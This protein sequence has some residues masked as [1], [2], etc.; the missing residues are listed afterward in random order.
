M[1]DR[2][3]N[4]IR[5]KQ[6]VPDTQNSS[7]NQYTMLA[8]NKSKPTEHEIITARMF[9]YPISLNRT[10][11]KY[12]N[13]LIGVTHF[14]YSNNKKIRSPSCLNTKCSDRPVKRDDL[15]SL[16]KTANLNSGD[17][18]PSLDEFGQRKNN[19]N[20]ECWICGK[21]GNNGEVFQY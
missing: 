4:I 6:R 10:T 13:E 21:L 11:Y 19:S 1:E 8:P 16:L 20:I 2:F 15:N 14:L 7:T 3:V 17:V 9:H 18:P 12:V 5:E